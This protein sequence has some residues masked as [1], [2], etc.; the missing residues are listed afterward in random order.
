MLLALSDG[1]SKSVDVSLIPVH[2]FLLADAATYL[3]EEGDTGHRNGDGHFFVA[4]QSR[5]NNHAAR[6]A[7]RV[8]DG[9]AVALGLHAD[10][11]KGHQ[12]G[13]AHLAA[14][15]QVE[16]ADS[17]LRLIAPKKSEKNHV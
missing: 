13:G 6:V 10:A 2:D 17:G 12:A 9:A 1:K 15:L 8:D 14:A 5:G 4:G 7:L 3:G 11:T 16:A